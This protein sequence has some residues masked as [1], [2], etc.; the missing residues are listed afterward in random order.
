MSKM[1][2]FITSNLFLGYESKLFHLR[3]HV[4][5]ASICVHVDKK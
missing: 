4:T 5:S 1:H 3:L 2:E